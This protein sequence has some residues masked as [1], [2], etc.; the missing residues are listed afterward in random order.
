MLAQ[1][2]VASPAV[3]FAALDPALARE[4]TRLYI[5]DALPCEHKTVRV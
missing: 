5:V 1:R 2:R 4:D 3:C